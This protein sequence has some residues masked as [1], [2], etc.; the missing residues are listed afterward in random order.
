MTSGGDGPEGFRE[1]Q[2]GTRRP[3]VIAVLLLLA[4][5]TLGS[6]ALQAEFPSNVSSP[7]HVGVEFR[8]PPLAPVYPSI[9]YDE[10][11]GITF[12]QNL[13]RIAVNVTAV[14]QTDLASGVGPAY[15]LNGVTA[16]GYWYQVGL[17]YMWPDNRGLASPGFNMDYEVFM[18]CFT[19]NCSSNRC[20]GSIFPAAC[21]AELDT[22]TVHPGDTVR[23]SLDFSGNYVVMRAL[24][25]NTNS[26]VSELWSAYGENQFLGLN[27]V[28]DN[29]GFF[30]GLM[31][32][33]YQSAEYDGTGVPVVYRQA[34]SNVS[35]GTM[36]VNE[37]DANTLQPVFTDWIAP[38]G[39]DNLALLQYFSSH[40][41]AEVAS[42]TELVTGLTPVTL[43]SLSSSALSNYRASEQ[44]RIGLK[45]HDPSGLTIKITSLTI[46]GD[47]GAYN[48]T[49]PAS[50]NIIGDSM[51]STE[52]TIPSR[53]TNGNYTVTIVAAYQ[54]LDVQIPG[55][56]VA[57]P[58]SSIARIQVG[59]RAT[60]STPP[61]NP[62]LM[63]RL[64][65]IIRDSLPLL[66]LFYVAA[67]IAL[68]VLVVTRRKSQTLAPFLGPATCRMCGG[69][70]DQT[71][72]FCP[73]C[74]STLTQ[75]SNQLGSDSRNQSPGHSSG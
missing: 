63:A 16:A 50:S 68:V 48:A 74:G 73:N 70:V 26:T 19:H 43:P 75:S 1:D 7:H 42:K 34:N 15:L 49:S 45:V 72:R 55:W 27:I 12:G 56:I 28:A 22:L 13:S 35:S 18:G 52:I 71:M 17:S 40:G 60:A 44:A 41:V 64:T 59:G 57:T 36:W 30:T 61:S 23:L 47:L 31:T 11:V 29:D 5:P 58:I 32:E 66:I 9:S 2:S 20:Q 46:S 8:S 38:T 53:T 6:T 51:F 10:Q 4:T 65:V 14:E 69:M 25:W 67:G 33:Q 62:T 54:F 37:F 21:G 24:D 39:L 3:F